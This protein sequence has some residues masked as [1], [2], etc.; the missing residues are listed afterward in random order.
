MYLNGF[1]YFPS[2]DNDIIQFTRL[3]TPRRGKKSKEKEKKKQSTPEASIPTPIIKKTKMVR[4]CY[5]GDTV[6]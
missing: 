2:R 3:P 4:T 6:N 5:H 1:A